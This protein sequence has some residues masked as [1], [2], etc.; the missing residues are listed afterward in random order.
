[1]DAHDP[2]STR[3]DLL[4]AA[5]R[6]VLRDGP[7]RLTLD[8][9]AREAGSSKG[10]VLYHFPTKD[11]LVV[12][13]VA[14]EL[15]RFEAAAAR[16]FAADRPTPGRALRAYVNATFDDA[17]PEPDIAAGLLAAVAAN[18]DLLAP[19]RAN[20]A[21]WQRRIA[22]DGLDPT[23]ATAVR[24][25]ADGLAF[26]DLFGAAPPA[27]DRHRLRQEL[28]ALAG[29]APEPAVRCRRSPVRR[30]RQEE[31]PPS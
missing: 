6:I 18:P 26:N 24:L 8:A 15:A 31:V 10:G 22:A 3:R 13:V 20:A 23:L 29:G 9:I 27:A 25:A 5:T 4:A 14:A 17:L 1:M 28:L 12:A 30:P 7:A 11:A 21:A 2:S 19:L 16:A